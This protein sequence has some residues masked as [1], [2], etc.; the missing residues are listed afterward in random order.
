[1]SVADI[2][3]RGYKEQRDINRKKCLQELIEVTEEAGL[4]DYEE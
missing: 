3:F 2:A 4:Y 1:M